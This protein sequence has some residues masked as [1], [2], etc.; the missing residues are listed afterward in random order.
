MS[1]K[2]LVRSESAEL[3]ACSGRFLRFATGF[4]EASGNFQR[5]AKEPI[6]PLAYTGGVMGTRL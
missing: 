1:N 4:S 3:Y 5:R 2:V 6:D